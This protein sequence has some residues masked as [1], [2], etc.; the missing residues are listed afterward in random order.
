MYIG[1]AQ[2]RPALDVV[3]LFVT[4]HVHPFLATLQ[5]GLVYPEHYYVRNK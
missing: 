5:S 3:D 4:D 2:V 1:I